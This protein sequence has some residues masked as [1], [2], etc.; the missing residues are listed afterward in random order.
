MTAPDDLVQNYLA[1][2]TERDLAQARLDEVSALLMKQMEADQRKS[3]RWTDD[4]HR[5]SVSYSVAH[6]TVIDEKGLRRALRAPVFDKYT[7]RVLDRKAMEAA[8]DAGEIDPITVSRFVT[9]KPSK[10]HLALQVKEVD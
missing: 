3:Y 1:A 8:M 10:P 7:K 9:L 4:D 6:T 2:R 5:Y